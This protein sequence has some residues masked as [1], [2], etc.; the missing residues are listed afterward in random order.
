[1]PTDAN[2]APILAAKE[3][4]VLLPGL[5]CQSGEHHLK[6]VPS[7]RVFIWG[8]WVHVDEWRQCTTASLTEKWTYWTLSLSAWIEEYIF[9]CCTVCVSE[10]CTLNEVKVIGWESE[11]TNPKSSTGKITL[12][13]QNKGRTCTPSNI[14][15]NFQPYLKYILKVFPC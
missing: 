1:M 12:I 14:R 4:D 11:W 6:Q 13:A 9:I 2:W 10:D 5:V 15:L 7:C 8:V 3:R